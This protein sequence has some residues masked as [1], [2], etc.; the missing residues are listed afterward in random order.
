M[1]NDQ[2]WR[3]NTHIQKKSWVGDSGVKAGEKLTAWSRRRGWNARKGRRVGGGEGGRKRRGGEGRKRG[4]KRRGGEGRKRG[5][6][7]REGG[8]RRGGGGGG[9]NW[10]ARDANT[11]CWGWTAQP[12]ES[13]KSSNTSRLGLDLLPTTYRC[14]SSAAVAAAAPPW[15]VYRSTTTWSGWA[16]WAAS[17]CACWRCSASCSS[18][19]ACR[20][21]FNERYKC[22]LEV[23]P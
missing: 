17:S 18:A 19:A 8:R 14:C 4:R 1:R 7:R 15:P 5:R 21:E 2:L 13:V 10:S 23:I 22:I 12:R 6:K 3:L 11:A 16:P 20:W 9:G